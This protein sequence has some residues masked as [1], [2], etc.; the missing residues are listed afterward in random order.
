MHPAYRY[1][2]VV[3]SIYDIRDQTKDGGSDEARAHNDR[4]DN[5]L[6]AMQTFDRLSSSMLDG[7]GKGLK[8]ALNLLAKSNPKR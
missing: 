3:A 6:D 8:L 1:R 2:P 5:M 7:K 4:L